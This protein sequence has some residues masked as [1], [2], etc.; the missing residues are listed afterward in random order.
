[1]KRILQVNTTL[2]IGGIES[3]L[4]NIYKGI[5]K[6]KYEFIFLCY[7]KEKFDFEEEITKLG[8]K[9]IR[10]SN[11]KEV[12]ILR[13]LR[14]II[15][16]IKREKIDIVHCHTY[17]DSGIV[18]LAARLT[19]V[20]IRIVHSHTT[21]GLNK[22]NLFRRIK[23]QIARSLIKHN[24]TM[25][26]ACSNDAGIA[27]FNSNNFKIVPNGIN[28]KKFQYNSEKRRE[29]REKYNINDD[30]V[31]GHVGRLDPAKN[32]EFM[33]K[34]LDKIVETNP[35]YK[36]MLI[37][38]GVLMEDIKKLVSKYSLNENV[39]FV[40]STSKVNDYYNAFDCFFFPSLYEGL[41]ISLIEAQ[42][43]GLTCIVSNNVPH[44][45]KLTKSVIFKD[46]TDD[47]N[48]W[49]DTIISCY[50]KRKLNN[51]QTISNTKYNL[52][53][54]VKQLEELYSKK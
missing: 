52:T 31:I 18:L 4:L 3:F 53:N 40:G 10:I 15:D 11:P 28:V 34:V 9:I 23:W 26:I 24:S 50:K 39:I 47:V 44:E 35:E 29:L 8:G 14:E 1:M 37:G 17:F 25:N 33:I 49:A 16:V 30:I 27:L 6:R 38:D 32:H 2:N 5:D 36:L 54:T 46:L 41:G 7:K 22:V 13:H 45:S 20:K 42:T 43:N 12:S 19:K 48:S 21:E 51:F